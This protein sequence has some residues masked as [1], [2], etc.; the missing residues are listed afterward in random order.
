ML[1][2]AS[3]FVHHGFA[4]LTFDLR[5]VNKSKHAPESLGYY[6]QRDVLG[7]VDF[8]QSGTLPYPQLGHPQAIVGWGI[9]MGAATL[10]LAAAQEPAI[11]AVVSDCA[12]G[13]VTSLLKMALPHQVKVPSLFAL[14]IFEASQAIYGVNLA[15]VRP[16]DVV[17]NLAPRPVFFIHGDND[18]V[19]P[20][21]QM[22]LLAQA[23]RST[24][25]AHVQTWMVTGGVGHAQSFLKMGDVYINRVVNFYTAVLGGN[26]SA[27]SNRQ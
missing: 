4:V 19:V 24:P 3:D 10:L 27:A 14:G 18:Q 21:A 20:P 13:D 11:Q 25:G 17:K 26:T 2:I 16:V 22:D 7:A 1:T 12:Y 9:S 5:A 6:E 23:A 8:L 15:A